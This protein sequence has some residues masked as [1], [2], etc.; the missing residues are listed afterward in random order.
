[1]KI[2]IRIFQFAIRSR[3]TVR[4]GDYHYRVALGIGHEERIGHG[5]KEKLHS[6]QELL[7][8]VKGSYCLRSRVL[9]DW[10]TGW[11][12]KEVSSERCMWMGE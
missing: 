11:R 10:G 3:M 12:R 9:R 8:V 1:M 5:V 7:H 2:H 4:K 6:R